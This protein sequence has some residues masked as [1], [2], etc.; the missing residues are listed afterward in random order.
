MEMWYYHNENVVPIADKLPVTRKKKWEV[1]VIKVKSLSS[2]QT[3]PQL[4]TTLSHSSPA[5][6][7]Q[8]PNVVTPSSIKK[9]KK[10]V[11]SPRCL[12]DQYLVPNNKREKLEKECD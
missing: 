5:H 8:I 4:N 6:S 11:L 7:T 10:S 9:R 12:I 2:S 1:S 3:S